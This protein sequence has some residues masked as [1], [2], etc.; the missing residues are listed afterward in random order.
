MKALFG[1]RWLWVILALIFFSLVIW[2]G[3]PYVSIADYA[4]LGSELARIIAIALLV[5]FWGLRALWRE[6]KAARA[7]KKLV[8]AVAKQ[9]DTVG[10]KSSADT[11]Q[12]QQ[13]FAEATEA[14]QKS[15]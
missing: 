4:P 2:F 7:S 12:M 8:T 5:V 14:L 6:V 11:R 15:S 9:E 1:K 13:R 10:A 3:G